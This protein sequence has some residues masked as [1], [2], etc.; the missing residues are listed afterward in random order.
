MD[1]RIKDLIFEKFESKK[2]QKYF[3]AQC[4]DD[5]LS[6]KEKTK[7]CDMASEFSKETNF[8]TLPEKSVETDIEEIVDFDGSIPSSKIPKNVRVVSTTARKTSNMTAKSARQPPFQSGDYMRRYWGEAE[9]DDALGFEDTMD[10][11]KTY[12][13]ALAHFVNE[14]GFDELDA[15]ER[16]EKMGYIPNSESKV[17]I[18]ERISKKQIDEYVDQLLKTKTKSSDIMNP[19]VEIEE[20][21]DNPILDRKL[22]YLM[23]LSD[24]DKK[25]I[26]NKLSN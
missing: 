15:K 4:N 24:E 2:Q 5:S 19:K 22:K 3:Y 20:M 10:A 6:K 21:D 25:Y 11:N 12:E 18:I 8:K 26:M 13:E 16:L 17:R 7:W 14:L 23:D 1:Q 9:M